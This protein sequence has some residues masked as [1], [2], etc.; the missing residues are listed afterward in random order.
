MRCRSIMIKLGRINHTDSSEPVRKVAPEK[1]PALMSLWP[2]VR[3]IG[4]A[5]LAVLLSTAICQSPA[6]A[7]AFN[8]NTGSQL[9][10]INVGM[11]MLDSDNQTGPAGRD[12]PGWY[13]FYILN[14]R[15]DIRPPGWN[16]DNPLAPKVITADINGRYGGVYANQIG[17]AITPNMAPY[18]E[19]DITRTNIDSLKKFNVL[20]I[21][22]HNN[23]SNPNNVSIDLTRQERL[24]LRQY[25]D[26]GGTLIVEDCG[27]AKT[28]FQFLFDA[29]FWSTG[30]NGFAVVPNPTQRHPIITTPFFLSQGDLNN[31]G[32]KSVGNYFMTS[33]RGTTAPTTAQP[34]PTIF[35]TVIG[36]SQHSDANGKPFPYVAAGDYGSGHVIM[37]SAD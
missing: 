3:L 10:T 29:Q 36:N 6:G 25:I 2:I 34:D 31:I 1:N 4:V 9:H 26:Q 13:S 16:L 20:V 8:Y 15:G 18:W 33:G 22:T 5:L 12:H 23:S 19:V 17:Q 11:L 32:D 37:S 7:A 30:S 24:L 35:N 21:H 14:Q 27:G 28:G